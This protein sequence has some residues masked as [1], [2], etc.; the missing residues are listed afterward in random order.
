M[1]DAK[2]HDL[3]LCLD[4]HRAFEKFSDVLYPPDPYHLNAARQ[5][6]PYQ[7]RAELLELPAEWPAETAQQ[8]I[9]LRLVRLAAA[10]NHLNSVMHEPAE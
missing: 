5:P 10:D 1:C 2:F 4:G 6:S 9:R 7:G 8:K 3:L